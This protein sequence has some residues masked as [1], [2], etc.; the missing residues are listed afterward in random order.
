MNRK[1][2]GRICIKVLAIIFGGNVRFSLFLFIFSNFPQ[3]TY[4]ASITI[5]SYF[6]RRTSKNCEF[7][8]FM[9]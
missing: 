5:N 3:C 7:T 8:T 2:S 1:R 6:K 4:T 9:R